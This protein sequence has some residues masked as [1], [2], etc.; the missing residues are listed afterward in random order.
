MNLTSS[1]ILSVDSISKA[2]K[3]KSES[4]YV[5]SKISFSLEASQFC[6]VFG[7]SGAGKTTLL[8]IIGGLDVPDEG[9]VIFEGKRI[10]SL[11]ERSKAKLRSSKIGIVFQN[12]NLVAHLTTLE[13]VILPSLFEFNE[14]NNENS[15][16][17]RAI[18]L[19]TRVGL[20]SKMKT[21]PT[22]LSDGEKRRVSVARAL[23]TEPK[24]ILADEPTINLDSENRD[25][26]LDLIRESTEKGAVAI[27]A[28]HDEDVSK[29]SDPV[30]H[31][32]FGKLSYAC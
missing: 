22:K 5:L 31:I 28:T 1:S 26:V 11:D 17:Q 25:A 9:K 14:S 23:L 13:N 12:P 10:D 29:L 20:E 24:L 15:R 32:K 27:V 3:E 18:S 30:L 21:M 8:N 6:A 4:L 2:Y 19:L 16:K 7:P